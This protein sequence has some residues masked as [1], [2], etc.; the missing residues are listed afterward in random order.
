M[1]E[2]I[3]DKLFCNYSINCRAEVQKL[4]AVEDYVEFLSSTEA[5]IKNFANRR[6]V[7][8]PNGQVRVLRFLR[9]LSG[10]Y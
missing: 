1:H 6:I 4:S 5:T 10:H 3:I 7:N 9:N 2:K 8:K